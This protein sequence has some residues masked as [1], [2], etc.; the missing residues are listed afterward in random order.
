MSD[1]ALHRLGGEGPD[2]LFIHGFGADRLSWLAVA[3]QLFDLATVWAVEYAGHGAAGNDPG[4]GDPQTI[5]S[6]IST[7]I[8]GKLTR[9]HIV[10]HSL[11]GT[12]SLHLAAM[13][14]D[15]LSGLLLLAP[16]SLAS[17]IDTGFVRAIPELDDLTAVLDLLRRLVSRKVL[18]TPR[19]AEAMLAGL[20]SPIRRSALR[21][22]AAA[23]ETAS[24]PPFP[25]P[26]PCA[27]LWVREDAIAAVPETDLPGLRIIEAVGH[28]P[29]IEAAGEVVSRLRTA[30]SPDTPRGP[31]PPRNT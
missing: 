2:L 21:R 24:L 26:V 25:S 27:I 20:D 14:P 18:V 29:H 5:A 3:P 1:V 7:A 6:A 10:G 28:M 8:D 19:M 31:T 13:M 9:P 12:L 4:N 15:D 30:L 11:G 22:I 17:R 16:A 23:L